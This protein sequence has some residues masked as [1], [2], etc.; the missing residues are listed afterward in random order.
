MAIPIYQMLQP[1]IL[2][3][4][5]FTPALP[6]LPMRVTK[7]IKL[8]SLHLALP[9]MPSSTPASFHTSS[10]HQSATYTAPW[11]PPPSLE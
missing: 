5:F 9:F 4:Y 11:F 1:V 8:T 2:P 3:L 10:P 7:D 6:M